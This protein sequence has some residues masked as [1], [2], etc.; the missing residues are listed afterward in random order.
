MHWIYRIKQKI[1]YQSFDRSDRPWHVKF[2]SKRIS[3]SRVC[4]TLTLNIS[5][6]SLRSFWDSERSLSAFEYRSEERYA[7]AITKWPYERN[8]LVAETLLPESFACFFDPHQIFGNSLRTFGQSFAS[9]VLKNFSGT[10]KFS[11]L[12]AG[13]S[14]VPP[15][16]P[17]PCGGNKHQTE[18]STFFEK[19]RH[20]F[21]SLTYGS[22]TQGQWSRGRGL[23]A[24]KK[25]KKI[26]FWQRT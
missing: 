9:R 14:R 8:N 22:V 18:R 17:K 20:D 19:N 11:S 3:V 6:K 10:A 24:F 13:A 12:Y 23:E 5:G 15:D 21:A 26:S 25:L 1:S 7:Y 16:G 2:M 4:T